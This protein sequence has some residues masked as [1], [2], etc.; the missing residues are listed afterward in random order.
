[1]KIVFMGTPDFAVPSLK[2][3]AQA[4]EN[5]AAVFTQPDKPKGRGYK[6]IPTPV[7]SAAL[8]IG[9]DVY[10]PASLRNGEDAVEA[11]RI[12]R[13]L[14]PDLIVVVAY[15]QILPEEILSLPE[16]G[17]IN[18]HGSLLPQYR[19]A[20]PMQW[21]LLNGEQKTGITTMMMDKGL[22]TGDM[23]MKA[24]IQIGENETLAELHDRLS[25][26][27]ADVLIKTIGQIKSGTLVRTPQDD[28]MSTY[29]PMIKKSMSLI[30]FSESAEAIHNKI[31]AITG[32]AF[33]GGKRLKIFRSELTGM[34][35]SEA[36]GTVADTSGFLVACG[37]GELI[38]FTEVQPEGGKRM[39]TA[40]YLRGVK[41]TEGIKFTDG[42]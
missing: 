23:L 33:L 31:R 7:K 42:E 20:A 40:D 9:A 36:A 19:G 37:N 17:C 8:E 25:E 15:G 10:Q 1:M 35:T 18:V 34:K 3:L 29:S 30:D 13:E 12:L 27:G 5:I 14:S 41:L 28:S 24:E 4:G 16:Y 22:D 38:R 6:M 32:Y 2:A 26:C 39:K 21:C 11:L